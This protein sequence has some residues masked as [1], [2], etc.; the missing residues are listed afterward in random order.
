MWWASPAVGSAS[1]AS[2]P[3]TSLDTLVA[4]IVGA[5]NSLRLESVV[6]VGHSIAGEEMT[7]FAELYPSRCTG[8]V[9]LDAAY[10]RSGIDTLASKQPS[11][12][13]PSIRPSD[14]TSFTSIRA[15]YARIS[16]VEQ[17]ESDIRATERFDAADRYQGSVTSNAHKARLGSGKRVARYD[18]A[19]CRAL[20]LYAVPDSVVDVVPYYKELD[21]KG[22][23]QAESLLT[24]TQ[25]VVADSR[26][27]I[28]RLPQ[29]RIIDLHGSNHY[30]FLQRPREVATAMRT[31]LDTLSSAQRPNDR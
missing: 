19:H 17:P 6:L 25:A 15:L 8:L 30:L 1:S 31:F 9:Y 12:P 23:V 22:R 29:Y 21:A 3:P 5:L 2:P 28:A 11:T 14:T 4:D 18:R 13:A 16:G 7:R 20:A 27:R 24:F 26:E 10:D